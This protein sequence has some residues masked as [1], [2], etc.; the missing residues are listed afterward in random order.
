MSVQQQIPIEVLK[1]GITETKEKDAQ[2]N[3]ITGAKLVVEPVPS[4][5]LIFY[6]DKNG[7]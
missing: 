6:N 3:N 4:R 7:D 5:L 2:R 1:E